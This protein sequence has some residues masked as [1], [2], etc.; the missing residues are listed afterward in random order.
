MKKDLINTLDDFI[1]NVDA[2]NS[3]CLL[4]GKRKV[5]EQHA[6]SLVR[7]GALLA[8]STK[9]LQFRSGNAGGADELFTK[10]VIAVAP[11][12][13]HLILSYTVHR[14]SARGQLKAT[15]LDEINLVEEPELVYKTK[16]VNTKNN[17]LIEK[18]TN[19]SRDRFAIK[20]A[21]LLRD[22]LMLLGSKKMPKA[23]IVIYY[24]DLSNPLAGGTGHTVRLAINNGIVCL[25]QTRWMNWL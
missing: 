6:D 19:G 24:D 9:L 10:G 20:A 3:I 22:S 17:S 13:M 12:R 23:T 7:L 11:E 25:N 21:Y 16:Q 2:A 1:Q 18:Y 14:K 8:S 15:A 4:I 5:D